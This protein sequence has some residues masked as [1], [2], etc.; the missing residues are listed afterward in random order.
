MERDYVEENINK[1]CL[2]E[3]SK[4]I[5]IGSVWKSWIMV[6]KS[7]YNVSLK[8]PNKKIELANKTLTL[9]SLAPH[10]DWVYLQKSHFINFVEANPTKSC[11]YALSRNP[12]ITWEFVQNNPDKPW[13]WYW[14]KQS[15]YYVGNRAKQPYKVLGLG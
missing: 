1:D 11:W 14:L 15:V 12:F 7:I 2:F 13:S 5:I 4:H 6:N 10:W 3:I 8:F 9:L